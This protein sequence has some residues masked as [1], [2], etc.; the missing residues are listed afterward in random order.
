MS[1]NDRPKIKELLMQGV[2]AAKKGDKTAAR[3]LF[4]KVLDLDKD[5]EDAWLGLAILADDPDEKRIFLGNVIVANPDNARA[6]KMLQALDT[7]PP[8]NKPVP[9]PTA[10]PAPSAADLRAELQA[11]PA[12]LEDDLRAHLPQAANVRS[13][14]PQLLILAGA[15][16]GVLALILVLMAVL[17]G[18]N[19]D[20]NKDQPQNAA[21]IVP[22]ATRADATPVA[23]VSTPQT[24]QATSPSSLPPTWTPEP[25]ATL[26]SEEPII[27][28]PTPPPGLPGAII[29]RSGQVPGDP[30]NAPIVL[31]KAD[32]SGQHVLTPNGRGHAPVLSPDSTQFAYVRYIPGTHDVLLQLNNIQGT[33]ARPGSVYWAGSVTLYQQDTPAWSPD[34]QWLAFTAVGMGATFP[35]LYRVSLAHR[36]G[37]SEALERLTDDDVIESWPSWSP[38]GTRLVYVADSSKLEFSASVDLRIYDTTDSSITPLTDDGG[39]LIESAPDWSPDG[40][41]VVFQAHAAESDTFDIYRISLDGAAPAEKLISS[42][43]NDIHPRYSPDGRYILFSSDRA[44]NWDVYIYD[45]VTHNT[46]QLTHSPYTDIG[47]DWGS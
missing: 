11:Q 46:Y 16:L 38:D 23:E 45:L 37:D 40:Q 20:D 2:Q 34:G 33:D 24:P 21:V 22:T 43:A 4:E 17:G 32:G 13:R 36:E 5:N 29:M 35:D 19:D 12:P 41:S 18:G 1:S 25:S 15:G 42:E 27:L 47:N 28:F 30:N 44:G 7:A 10:P 3:V 9:P 6:Q 39:A 31:I 14:T 8:P 26:P